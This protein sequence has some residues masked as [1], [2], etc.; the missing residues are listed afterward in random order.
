MTGMKMTTV[1]ITPRIVAKEIAAQVLSLSVKTFERL[2]QQGDI[3]KPRQ[4][5]AGRVGWLVSELDEW[6]IKRPLSQLLP[7][8]NTG[9][10]KPRTHQASGA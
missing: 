2:V 7:P 9:A 10:K 1:A 8:E 3:P 6:A 5:S 4:I